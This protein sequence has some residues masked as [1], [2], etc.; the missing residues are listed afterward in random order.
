MKAAVLSIGTELTRGE[1]LNTN[2]F[3]LADKLTALG[4]EVTRIDCCDD[5]RARIVQ[6]LQQ[7]ADGHSVIVSTGGLGP[8]TDDIT[9][10]CVGLLLGVP[11]ERDAASLAHI[12]ALFQRIGRPMTDNNKKQ[13]DFPKGANILA[14]PNGTAPGFSVLIG[15]AH[16]FFTPGVPREMEPMFREHISKAIAPLAPSTQKQM[17]FRTFGKAEAEIGQLLD[18]VEAAYQGII[19]GYR[20]HY[21]EIEVKVLAKA[22]TPEAAAT[23]CERAAQDVR[24]RLGSAIMSEGDDTLVQI[25]SKAYRANKRTLALAESCTGGLVAQMLTAEPGASD[26]FVGGVVAYADR[27]KTELLGV[28]A[29][30]I[31]KHGAVSKEVALAMADGA[32]TR[33]NADVAIAITGI[34]GPGGAT[35]AKPVGLV[36]IAV[37]DSVHEYK[38]RGD[39]YRIQRIAAYQALRLAL[40]ASA[41]PK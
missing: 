9:T 27:V 2:S 5:D 37:N 1:L 24:A 25:V 14:N 3:W 4:F 40:N 7:L 11:L 19:V 20:A 8:T 36:F 6:S 41:S 18:G 22:A 33:L 15:K 39:R 30:L 38:F 32:R 10:E 23:L 28:P 34:A 17:R 35:G 26:V 13:A 12:E 16:A 21:P 31:E 29:A